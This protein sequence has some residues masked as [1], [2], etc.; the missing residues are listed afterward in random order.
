MAPRRR[1]ARLA[2]HLAPGETSQRPRPAPTSSAARVEPG[3]QTPPHPAALFADADAPISWAAADWAAM[4][5]RQ[6]AEPLLHLEPALR[7]FDMGQF[8]RDG[9]AVFPGIMRP[10]AQA[11]WVESLQVAQAHNDDFVRS[12]WGALDWSQLGCEPPEQRGITP[13]QVEAA[14]MNSQNI[15][16]TT[17][18][19]DFD[20]PHQTLPTQG[21]VYQQ[22]HTDIAGVRTLRRHSVIPE[23]VQ[24]ESSSPQ[25]TGLTPPDAAQV[26]PLR[27]HS[28][29]HG[30]VRLLPS[31]PFYPAPHLDRRGFVAQADAPRH[32]R[33]PHRAAG[34]AERRRAAL[35][36][37]A[38]VHP[39]SRPQG[40]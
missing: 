30:G 5:E 22:H 26:L 32:A 10:R 9:V 39:P 35:R 7:S 25:P 8:L 13:E 15:P 28:V 12:D 3:A 14:V 4:A 18:P 20:R 31:P 21:A 17:I 34:P 27:P 38:A 1:L 2:S 36:P 37:L 40:Q 16:S 23:Y 29:P 6:A 33:A 24:Y 19:S 11:R